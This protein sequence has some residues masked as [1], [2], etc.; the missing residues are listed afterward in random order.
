MEKEKSWTL[1]HS[2][3]FGCP[4]RVSAVKTVDNC[5]HKRCPIKQ[6]DIVCERIGQIMTAIRLAHAHREVRDIITNLKSMRSIVCN[7]L[8]ATVWKKNLYLKWSI[9]SANMKRQ[10]CCHEALTNCH[11]IFARVKRSAHFPLR[12]PKARFIGGSPASFFMR[13]RR[14]SL[15][16]ASL[17]TCF[18]LV[19]VVRNSYTAFL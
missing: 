6:G 12:V 13:R 14:A 1:S 15:K 18:F 2:R 8:L 17:A 9:C 16:K 3:F 11:A 19:F 7:R 5:F 4:N 10:L